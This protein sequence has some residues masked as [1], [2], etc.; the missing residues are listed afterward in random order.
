MDAVRWQSGWPGT[1]SV[2]GIL[3]APLES[4]TLARPGSAKDR[5]LLYRWVQERLGLFCSVQ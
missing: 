2:P 1:E 3:R 4:C 5:W